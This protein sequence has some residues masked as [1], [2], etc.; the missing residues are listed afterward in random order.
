LYDEN[1]KE[2]VDWAA[3][4]AVNALGHSDKGLAS[5]VAKQMEKIQHTSNLFHTSEPL[6]LAK[7]MVEKSVYFDKVFFCN[8]GTE[9]NEA[10]MKFAKKHFLVKA[11]KKALHLPEDSPNPPAFQGFTCKQPV[12]P[13]GCFT[14]GGMCGCWPQSSHNDIAHYTR[15][16]IIAFKGGFHG[17]SMGSLSATHKPQIRQPFGPF[18]PDVKFARFNNIKDVEKY[19][20]NKTAAVIVEPVQGEGGIYPAD[21]TFMKDL[22]AL[23]KE[24]E[25]LLIL[26]EVQCGL[27]RTGRLFAHEAYDNLNP[28]MMS[29]AK[30]LAG[31]LPIGALMVTDRIASCIQPGDHGTT[32]GGNPLVATAANYVFSRIS[33]PAFLKETQAVGAF[34]YDGFL[35]LQQKYPQHIHEVRKTLDN[36]LYFGVELK[37]NP[38]PVLSQAAEHGLM[39]ITA[40]ENTLRICPPLI[41]TREEVEF[42]LNVLDKIFKSL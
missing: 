4:I 41:I 26:D 40:G 33:N 38:K 13:S 34:M 42:G 9:A 19:I 8:S 21:R 10:A 31:G 12:N 15:N 29:L 22:S 3:G 16:E 23:V 37:Q 32:F 20:S 7:Q 35:K 18:P 6:E 1:G 25:A 36:G 24:H 11:Q 30:P 2:Y 17:R 27:G 14:R 39:I 5:V 28:D